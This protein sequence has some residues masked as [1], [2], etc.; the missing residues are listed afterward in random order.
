MQFGKGAL[1]KGTF[2]ANQSKTSNSNNSSLAWDGS[3]NH[4]KSNQTKISAKPQ[5]FKPAEENEYEEDGFE[6]ET[7]SP[8]KESI[9]NG[10]PAKEPKKEN[11]KS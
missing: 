2:N 5:V 3:H 10:T 7:S 9:A 1:K 6:D 4:G 8:I 11:N